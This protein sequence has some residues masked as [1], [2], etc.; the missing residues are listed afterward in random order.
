MCSG[1][2]LAGQGPEPRWVPGGTLTGFQEGLV[3]W[4]PEP[5]QFSLGVWC[6][7]EIGPLRLGV[8]PM[9][10]EPPC[11]GPV[12]AGLAQQGHVTGA[13]LPWAQMGEPQSGPGV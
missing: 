12:T 6:W 13:E 9:R 5:G 10:T 1:P 3:S 2:S 7:A 11:R 4:S 8:C